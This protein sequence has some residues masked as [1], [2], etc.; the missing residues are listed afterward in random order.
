M[1]SLAAITAVPQCKAQP[2]GY[3]DK[4]TQ[5]LQGCEGTGGACIHERDRQ[6]HQRASAW[7]LSLLPWGPGQGGRVDLLRLNLRLP[8]QVQ[9]SL[10]QHCF[11][12]G[13]FTNAQLVCH[14]QFA[15][16]PLAMQ[17]ALPA[18]A[19]SHRRVPA[20]VHTA[21]AAGVQRIQPNE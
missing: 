5:Y 21:Y 7:W 20:S 12:L 2:S 14:L 3:W 6:T 4:L 9:V 8:Y 17:W 19:A 1:S 18:S 16:G 10:Q 11:W 13:M 15:H